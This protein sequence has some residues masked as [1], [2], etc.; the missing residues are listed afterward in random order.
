MEQIKFKR[1]KTA[2]REFANIA[3]KFFGRSLEPYVKYFESIK[4]D[5][6]MA[7]L[8]IGFVEYVYAA[9]FVTFMIFLFELPL[10]AVIFSILFK[11]ALLGFLLSFTITSFITLGIFF[12]FYT[13]PSIEAG[14][15]QKAI[16]AYLPFA[17]TYMATVSS[18]GSPPI[19][20]FK[21]LAGLKT[22]GEL[23]KESEKIYRDVEAFGMDI[24]SAIRK[25]ASR[26]PSPMFKELLWGLDTVISS[27][28]NISEYLRG[29]SRSY[30]Q[31]YKRRLQAYSS[32]M[33]LL[34][35]VYLTVILVGS[36]FFVIMTAIMSI[37]GGTSAGSILMIQFLVVFM[38]LPFVSIG[39]I[40][41]LKG[42]AP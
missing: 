31:E 20:M 35:E 28:S 17:T 26:T 16:E 4:P 40:F 42:L 2:W 24:L 5:L 11:N 32:L 34:M 30:L 8:D 18:G 27:G 10:L 23:S 1:K 7:N 22:F 41:L 21:L 39:F 33:S 9:V 15:R 37:F 19:S 3:F 12:F 29:K 25:T 6:L 38:G 36:I 14:R 13:Y